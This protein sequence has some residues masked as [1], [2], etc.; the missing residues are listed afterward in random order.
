MYDEG[1][2]WYQ[3][4]FNEDYLKLY[5]M[6]NKEEAEKQIRFL[7]ENLL[8]NGDE[9]ILDLGCGTGR[10]SILFADKGY[11]VVGVDAS[12]TFIQEAQRSYSDVRHLKFYLRDMRHIE[13]LGKF[14]V[15]VSMFTSFS[16]RHA[17]AQ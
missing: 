6:R 15:A 10:H 8:L 9:R 14:D 4:W 12:P 17:T 2:A 3:D 13:D 5:K 16:D 7:E 1:E 11:N